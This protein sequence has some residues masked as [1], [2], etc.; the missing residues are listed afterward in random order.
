MKYRA[1]IVMV[2]CALL[3]ACAPDGRANTPSANPQESGPTVVS[4]APSA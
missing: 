3:V 2:T 4:P 1:A